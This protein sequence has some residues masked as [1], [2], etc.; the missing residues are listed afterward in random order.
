MELTILPHRA[1][2]PGFKNLIFITSKINPYHC[3]DGV[4]LEKNVHSA[5]NLL[6][7]F[8]DDVEVDLENHRG[9]IYNAPTEQDVIKALEFAAGKSRVVVSCHAGISRSSAMAAVISAKYNNNPTLPLDIRYHGPNK[10]IIELGEKILG[11]PLRQ[12]IADWDKGLHSIPEPRNLNL[13]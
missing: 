1:I 10:K 9:E 8:F 7:L 6:E 13:F 11:I 2:T 12:I 3:W 4:S 5:N